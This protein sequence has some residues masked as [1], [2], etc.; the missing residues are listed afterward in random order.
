MLRI[1]RLWILALVVV[2]ALVAA[3]L[4]GQD[5][6]V[7]QVVRSLAEKYYNPAASGLQDFEVVVRNPRFEKLLPGAVIRLYWKA[8]DRKRAR[9]ENAPEK[10]RDKVPQLE[11]L[12]SAIADNVVPEGILQLAGKRDVI[13]TAEGELTHVAL[14]SRAGLV[15]PTNHYWFDKDLRM[16]RAVS[17]L[18]TQGKP[19]RSDYNA[20]KVQEQ[21]GRFLVEEMKGSSP[22]GPAEIRWEYEKV[23]GFW[24]PVKMVHVT[25]RDSVETTQFL[26]YKVNQGLS[27][28]VFK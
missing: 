6:Q 15:D 8:P 3:P 25:G 23:G 16:T 26:D 1:S 12:F 2:A 9:I 14:T 4:R 24:L 27:E 17:E 13:V 22:A 18:I 28:E 7:P 19:Q 11:K 10:A 20:V 21:D 5:P